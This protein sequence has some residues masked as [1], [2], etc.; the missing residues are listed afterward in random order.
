ME[1]CEDM[2]WWVEMNLRIFHETETAR[3]AI[4]ESGQYLGSERPAGADNGTCYYQLSDAEF[5]EI[6]PCLPL[7]DILI[8]NR[9]IG[10]EHHKM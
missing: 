7:K 8:S 2:N 3:Q 10:K 5:N 4:R 1:V 9:G 6:H